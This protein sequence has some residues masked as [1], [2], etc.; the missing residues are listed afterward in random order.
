M[1]ESLNEIFKSPPTQRSNKIFPILSLRAQYEPT[2][3]LVVGDNILYWGSVLTQNSDT[4]FFPAFVA[5]YSSGDMIAIQASGWYWVHVRLGLSGGTP[6]FVNLDVYEPELNG[7]FRREIQPITN[8]GN[9][10]LTFFT[11]INC[12]LERGRYSKTVG[13]LLRVSFTISTATTGT[14]INLTRNSTTEITVMGANPTYIPR[15]GKMWMWNRW[16]VTGT[17][18]ASATWTTIEWDNT[19]PSLYGINYRGLIAGGSIDVGGGD[20]SLKGGITVNAGFRSR[21]Y[22]DAESIYMVNCTILWQ[23]QITGVRNIV[24]RQIGV[25]DKIIAAVTVDALTANALYSSVHALVDTTAQTTTSYVQV[26]VYQNSGVTMNPALRS[27]SVPY[28]SY[29]NSFSAIR[30]GDVGV[31]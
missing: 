28:F 20:T 14:L 13:A 27:P 25:T 19:P 16:D 7:Q 8:A 29:V 24:L 31:L 23:P 15:Q 30:L 26:D 4:I 22:L 5:P 9:S 10:H 1:S 17:S 6:T 18:V 2:S 12:D 11:Y 21:I 3:A